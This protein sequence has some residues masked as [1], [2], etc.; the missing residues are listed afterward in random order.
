MTVQSIAVFYIVA[1]S[2]NGILCKLVFVMA[3]YEH[4]FMVGSSPAWEGVDEFLFMGC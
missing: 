2:Y 1:R 3:W 4:L